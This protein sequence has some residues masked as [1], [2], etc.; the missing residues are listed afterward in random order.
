MRESRYSLDYVQIC[1]QVGRAAWVQDTS[2]W[3]KLVT[4]KKNLSRLG[5]CKSLK[6]NK[7]SLGFSQDLGNA[8]V[9]GE[10]EAFFLAPLFSVKPNSSKN[11]LKSY[12]EVCFAITTIVINL[13]SF[14]HW[15]QCIVTQLLIWLCWIKPI[16]ATLY[17]SII[18]EF[19]VHSL[20]CSWTIILLIVQVD[21]TLSC[22]SS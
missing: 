4:W 20:N 16:C 7:R 1:N 14:W 9:L 8:Q 15:Q 10:V 13:I 17:L 19:I 6:Q 18:P 3:F 2:T 11:G 22:K 21:I 5:S 12:H